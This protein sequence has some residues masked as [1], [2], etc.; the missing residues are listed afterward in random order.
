MAVIRLSGSGSAELVDRCFQ[1]T[2]GSATTA[3]LAGFT[4]LLGTVR[5]EDG[6]VI[7]QVVVTRFAAPRSY[8]GEDLVEISCHGGTAVK[9]ALLERFCAL[10]AR[11]AEP[12]EF[13][14]RAFLSGKMDLSQAEAV[15]DL[16]SASAE[17]SAR[18]AAAQMGGSLAREARAYADR[19]YRL[20]AA[21]EMAVEYPDHDQ[22]DSMPSASACR[23]E[24]RRLAAWASGYARGRMLREGLRVTL[25]GPPN[26]GKSSLLNALARQ[27]RAIV[28]EI[29]GTTRDTVDVRLEM[30]GIPVILTDTAG[31]RDGVDP[32]EKQGIERARQAIDESDLVFWLI[33]ADLPPDDR[34]ADERAADWRAAAQATSTE[35]LAVVAKA[36]LPEADAWISLLKNRLGSTPTACSTQSGDGLDAL[37]RIMIQHYEKAGAASSEDL[38]I[39]NVRHQQCLSRAAERAAE[40]AD[41]LDA[42]LPAEIIAALLHQAIEALRELTGDDVSEH[43][44]D[45][46]FSRFCVGK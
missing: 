21:L 28:S 2:G 25:A 24:S 26:S 1:S 20:L 27:N 18:A 40:A 19:L 9:R 37:R 23:D 10:G 6:S 16:I 4:C 31:L 39:T 5:R 41:G 38:L 22:A 36:D 45:Q 33:P 3:G 34:T 42:G 35:I 32:I 15:I 14:R 11:L 44:I 17:R 13:T 29:P 43:L 12:G 8:T 7:D 30:D 46:I